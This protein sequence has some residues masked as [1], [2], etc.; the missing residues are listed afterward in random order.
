MKVQSTKELK[1]LN[2]QLQREI[3]ERKQIEEELQTQTHYL[4]ERMKELSCLYGISHLVEKQGISLQDILQGTVDLIPASWQYPEITCARI[5]LDNLDLRSPNFRET[6]WKQVC[7]MTVHNEWIGTVEVYYLEEKPE[8]DEGPFLKEE[9]S[10]IDAIAERLGRIVEHKRIEEALR[11]SETKYATLVE[12]ALDGVLITQDGVHKF[13][14]QGYALITG[15]AV[16]EMEGMPFLDLVVPECKNAIADRYRRRLAGKELSISNASKIR[17]KDGTVKEIES[18]SSIIEYEG[19]PAVLA[20]VRDI[21]ERRRMEEALRESEGRFRRLFEESNDAVFIHDL[22]GTIHDV[23]S[24]ACELL[25]Y[26]KDTLRR[27]PLPALHPEEELPVAKNAFQT[28]AEEGGIRFESKFKK[29]DGA[30]I[31]VDI[32][33]RVVDAEKGIVQGIVR[34][35]TERKR[36]DEKLREAVERESRMRRELEEEIEKRAEFTRALVHE[37]KTP[38]TPML[39]SSQLLVEEL[40]EQPWLRIAENLSQGTSRLNDRIDELLDVA[41]GELGLLQLNSK[42]LDPLQLLRSVA[43]DMGPLA[44]SREQSLILELP[45]FLSS[46]WADEDRLRQ[47]LLNLLNNAFK[48]TPKGGNVSLRAREKGQALTVEVQDTGPGIPNED[49]QR[50]FEPYYRRKSDG[51]RRDGLGLGLSLCKRLIESHGGTIWVKSQKGKG[52]NFGFSV[53]LNAVDD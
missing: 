9:R 29:S 30:T 41:K 7:S 34:D 50:I 20:V 45:S 32:S 12:Q 4:D 22:E 13:I 48:W 37:L 18:R 43:D 40:Q 15:Y 6:I 51:S 39:V 11:Q 42:Q 35:I 46:V 1:A 17:C 52:C 25:G 53:P 44:S 14:N 23:N 16:E 3:E 33:S 21:T 5:V 27:I 8:I 28:S 49:E 38:L 10:L 24:K 2:E 19:R 36:A 31:N 26:D 47:V